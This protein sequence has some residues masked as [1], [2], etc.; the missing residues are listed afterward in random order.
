MSLPVGYTV[1]PARVE[2][3]EQVLQL[4]TRRNMEDYGEPLYSSQDLAELWNV[5]DME[6]DTW[7]VL[8]PDGKIAAY[9]DLQRRGQVQFDVSFFNAAGHPQIEIGS[10]LLRLAEVRA[11]S[12]AG[13]AVRLIGRVGGDNALA[14]QSFGQ[15]GFIPGLTFLL[16]EISTESPPTAPQWPEGIGVRSFARGRDEQI[17]YQVDEEA[18]LDKGYHH[19]LSFQ[20]WYTRRGIG[21]LDFDPS[22]WF[23]ACKDEQ[24]IGA[25]LNNFSRDSRTGWVDHLSVLREWRNKGIGTALLHYSFGVFYGR[26]VRKVKLSVDSG[27]LT[28]APRLYERVGMKAVQQYQIF[29]KTTA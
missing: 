28:N 22:L 1:G 25:A 21:R 4:I 2:D 3:W 9:A 16:M 17:V 7:V 15:A 14:A 27:S 18:S 6:Q 24:V 11:V 12:A 19:P 29:S 10:H 8:S 26:G 23:L 13:K 5:L 20:S